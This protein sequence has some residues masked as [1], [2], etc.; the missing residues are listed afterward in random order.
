ME[1][2]LINSSA[3]APRRVV[4]IL[5]RLMDSEMS[6]YRTMG[7]AV[8]CGNMVLYTAY[9]KNPLQGSVFPI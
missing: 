9:G 3:P 8:M 5:R 7:P 6:V 4:F 2:P 1:R